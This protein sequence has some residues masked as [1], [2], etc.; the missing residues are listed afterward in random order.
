MKEKKM[1]YLLQVGGKSG[2]W[3]RKSKIF[4]KNFSCERKR[5]NGLFK[6]RLGVRAEHKLEMAHGKNILF[7]IIFI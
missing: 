6:C 1:V 5:Q 4:K 7:H 3:F 2:K